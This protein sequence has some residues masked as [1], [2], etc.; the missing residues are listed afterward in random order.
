VLTGSAAE[1]MSGMVLDGGW[2]VGELVD[3]PG[4]TGG[5]FSVRYNVS[6]A[7]GEKAFLKA[8]DISATLSQSPDVVTALQKLLSDY[9]F[10]REL[11]EKCR[12]MS[13]VVRGLAFGQA[14]VSGSMV[15]PVP[16][17]IFELADGGDVRRYLGSLSSA[18][19]VAWKLRTLH[20]IAVA[21]QQLHARGIA[22]QDVKP[23]N[24]LVFDERVQKLAD[25]G[26]ASERGKTGPRDHLLFAGDPN[27]P[28]LEV[29][30]GYQ[31]QDWDERRFGYDLYLLGS[32]AAY[33][34]A[35]QPMSAMLLRH[36]DQRF[37]PQNWTGTFLEVLPYLE[38]AFALALSELRQTIPD[39][40]LAMEISPVLAELCNPDPAR[41]G[42]PT[43]RRPR[44]RFALEHYVSR[45]DHFAKLATIKARVR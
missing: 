42:V 25:L 30:Y 34:F 31:F 43:S 24:V 39:P 19:D 32:M 4:G 26:C 38:H 22:H 27:Y 13:K 41:R 12:R 28:P 8:L 36:L 5:S 11:V 14:A 45:F 20:Q 33:F 3:P 40:I 21:L 6:S 10:E 44:S 7:T 18:Q 9:D 17:L 1:S 35:Q 15:G 16:Y 37:F 23:S 2:T 29:F